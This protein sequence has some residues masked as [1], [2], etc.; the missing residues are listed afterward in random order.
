MKRREALKASPIGYAKRVDDAGTWFATGQQ[1]F[2]QVEGVMK[3]TS[4]PA[5]TADMDTWEPVMPEPPQV[6]VAAAPV[7]Q[8]PTPSP[9]PSSQPAKE[10][11]KSRSES[12]LK[13]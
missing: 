7:T 8:A 13:K 10:R 4:W 5:H 1:M 9:V 11:H 2:L 6:L 3:P 12:R